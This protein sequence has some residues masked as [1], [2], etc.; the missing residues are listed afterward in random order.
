[1]GWCNCNHD[2]CFTDHLQNI[3]ECVEEDYAC[4]CRHCRQSI[5]ND[6]V[7]K[8]LLKEVRRLGEFVNNLEQEK[9]EKEF[10]ESQRQH[11]E[12]KALDKIRAESERFNILD[13]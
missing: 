5:H 8:L 11:D 10:E 4:Q 1:M 2:A 7:I 3:D 6:D 9:R 12:L 13:L